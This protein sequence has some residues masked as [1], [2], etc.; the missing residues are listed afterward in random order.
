MG[1]NIFRKKNKRLVPWRNCQEISKSGKKRVQKIN[2]PK[3]IYYILFSVFIITTVYIFFF[4]SLLKINKI[5]IDGNDDLDYGN[6]VESLNSMLAGKYLGIVPKNNILLISDRK[7]EKLLAENF[8]KISLVEVRKI[9]PDEIDIR[10]VERK[11]LLFFCK[12]ELS[13]GN[14]FIVDENGYAY[15]KTDANLAGNKEDNLISVVDSSGKN[16][17]VGE[18]IYSRDDIDFI[19]RIREK[20]D[21][22]ITKTAIVPIYTTPSRL[23]GEFQIITNEGWKIIISSEIPLEQTVRVLKTFFEKNLISDRSSLEYVDARSENRIDYK[24]KETEKKEDQI[25]DEMNKENAH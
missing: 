18:K 6:I 19:L 1:I 17:E 2:Y 12:K 9:F 3:I 10:I 16:V 4:S 23:S 22:S 11:S 20:I 25:N 21:N 13:D 8:S 15:T 24:L 5:V 14:C 7:A